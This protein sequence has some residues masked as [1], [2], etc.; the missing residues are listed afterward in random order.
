MMEINAEHTL[1]LFDFDGTLTRKD[2]LFELIKFIRG[3]QTFY[4]GLFRLSPYLF[5]FKLGVIP[6]RKAKEKMLTYFFK[7]MPQDIFQN[8]CNRFASEIVPA[9]L[10]KGALPT[11]RQFKDSGTRIVIVTASAENWIMPW[12]ASMHVE[13]IASKIEIVD[14]KITG[15]LSGKNCHGLEKV[16]R[17]KE[18]IDLSQ[19]DAIY[20]FG[21]SKGDLPMLQLATN[22]YYKSFR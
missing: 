19:Y 14:G 16:Y 3:K 11:L 8:Y 13:Y 18:A 5:L 17:I 21:D 4:K 20:A 12:C 10:R 22:P 15:K 6:N 9:L 7:G 1:A 2:S